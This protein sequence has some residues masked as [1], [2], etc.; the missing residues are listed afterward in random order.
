MEQQKL[1]NNDVVLKK[2]NKSIY[3]FMLNVPN[4]VHSRNIQIL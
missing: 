2:F 1:I 3:S 4:S